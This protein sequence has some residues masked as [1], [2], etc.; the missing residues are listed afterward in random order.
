MPE[1][2]KALLLESATQYFDSRVN[3]LQHALQAA[4]RAVRSGAS[5]QLIVAALCHD[6][7]DVI[8]VQNHAAI[9]AEILKPYVSRDVYDI[10][11][12]HQDFQR[13]HYGA[14]AEGSGLSRLRHV[15]RRWYRQACVFSDEWDQTS[16]DPEYDT[17]PLEYFEPMI[18]RVFER[19]LQTTWT[20]RAF[21]LL[22]AW[23]RI[24]L[25]LRRALRS[26][27]SAERGTG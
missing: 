22:R 6:L 5:E 10:V 21:I 17:L 15:T 20:S 16:F 18:A 12:T 1:R 27:R 2:V 4:S 14:L 23:N 7:G 9:A 24:G 26:G 19:P 8:S 13:R 3:Q 11:R 25:W